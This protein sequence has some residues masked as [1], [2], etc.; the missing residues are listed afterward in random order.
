[1]SVCIFVY[2]YRHRLCICDVFLSI[3]GIAKTC[4][5]FLKELRLFSFLNKTARS[6]RVTGNDYVKS[7]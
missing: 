5:R 6:N 3:K 1:M 4:K 7:R 2:F